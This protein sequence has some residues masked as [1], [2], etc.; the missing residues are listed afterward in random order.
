MLRLVGP[1]TLQTAS[2]RC[3]RCGGRTAVHAIVAAA[4]ID[5][6]EAHPVPQAPSTD[7]RAFVYDLAEHQLPNTLAR[8]IAG[9]AENFRPTYS[10]TRSEVT[11]AN[12]CMLCGSLQGAHY[13]HSSP[14]G[15][16]FGGPDHTEAATERH[17]AEAGCDIADA[18]YSY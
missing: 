3:W 12:T 16:F 1:L 9:V 7:G 6:D 15:P 8:C 14:D 17:L 4:V 10:N 2:A 11:W 13:L 18:S 5:I